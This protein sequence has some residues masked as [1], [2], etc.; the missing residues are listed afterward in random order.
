[1]EYEIRTI[2]LSLKSSRQKVEK[3]LNESG[4]KLDDTDY[5]AG[6][7]RMEDDR[8]LACG[9]LKK[10]IIKC[11]AVSDELKGTGLSNSLISHLISA[12]REQNTSTV[13]VFTKPE[14]K[15]IFTSLGFSVLASAPKAI[16]LEN[17]TNNLTNYCKY[18]ESHK[19]EGLNG[20]IVMNCNPFTKGHRYLIEQAC[21]QVDNL[22]V[23]PVK[24]D[25]SIFSYSERKAMIEQGVKDLKN[26]TVLD[27]S[28][29]SI[30]E[31]TF[32]TYFLKNL[33]DAADTHIILDLDVFVKF[34][35]PALNVKCR[36]VGSEPKDALTARYNEL[37]KQTL[38]LKGINVTEIKRLEAKNG[39]ISA[40]Q[41]RAYVKENSLTKAAESAFASTLP[42]LVSHLATNALQT[43]L[44]LTPKP[45]L[46]DKNDSGAHTDMDYNLMYRSI[47]AL[48]PYFTKLALL[49]FN[50]DVPSVKDM[51]TI[52]LEAEKA[53]F[54]ATGGVNTHKGALF[55]LGLTCV[56]A[57][58]LLYLYQNVQV[59]ALR[60]CIAM[61]AGRFA[62][63]EDTHGDKVLKQN[64]IKGALYNAADG[65]KELFECWLP[66]YR[67]NKTDGYVLYKLLLLIMSQLDDTNIYYR[68]GEQTVKTVKKQAAEL[69]ENFSLS[70]LE[71]LNTEYVRENI[72]S[73]GAADM[74]SLTVLV[75]SLTN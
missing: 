41:L 22:Y 43:E 44:D 31:L 69:L 61:L 52:G 40:S 34:I 9:G 18:L 53:M 11:I 16:L 58:H 32:P 65:Y 75:D 14:N 8:I 25:V 15:E 38:Q 24:E 70:Q 54:E 27:G 7:F 48:H 13:R 49:G 45:G 37:M 26:V 17:N 67:A 3:F 63:P 36:F 71:R 64:K 12:A 20:C 35:A 33:T 60:E 73:G 23:I 4:L 28:D 56:C 59:T 6:V 42:Y 46:V 51:Q 66:F 62:Q 21:K 1:M 10:N 30:S 19:K 74:L 2:P 72:S 5:F 57:T 39:V 47:K 68:K 29:Y 55:S 50:K